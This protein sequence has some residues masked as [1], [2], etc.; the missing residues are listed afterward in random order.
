MHRYMHI[1]AYMLTNISFS[2]DTHVHISPEGKN[3][4]CSIAKIFCQS[5]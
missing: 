4:P 2:Y 3:L 1:F 5:I